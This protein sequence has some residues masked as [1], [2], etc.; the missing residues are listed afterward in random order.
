MENAVTRLGLDAYES[1]SDKAM[2]LISKLGIYDLE[3][4]EWIKDPECSVEDIRE[5]YPELADEIK[6]RPYIT[7]DDEGYGSFH[8]A[9]DHILYRF[10]DEDGTVEDFY[11]NITHM[12]KWTM[13]ASY[14]LDGL[15]EEI[16]CMKE[17]NVDHG[18][19]EGY[20][21]TD[22]VCKIPTWVKLSN[23]CS[24]QGKKFKSVFVPHSVNC[25]G[26]GT[27]DHC[28]YLEEITLPDTL[29]YVGDQMFHGCKNLKEISF[30]N[31]AVLDEGAMYKCTSL[32]KVKLP[33]RLK[34]IR[35]NLLAECVSLESIRIPYS[36]T[37]IQDCAFENCKSLTSMY[38]PDNVKYI[39]YNVFKGCDK[40][41]EISIPLECKFEEFPEGIKI[42][43]RG[44]DLKSKYKD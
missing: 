12:D 19:L 34:K 42:V 2:Q 39:G 1:Q 13:F 20:E 3:R 38:I 41:T 44:L 43:T 9:K 33:K 30:P 8:S 6:F 10:C 26:S 7:M 22:E 25:L 28:E 5:I 29:R 4:D 37:E 27:F 14:F 17:F 31:K 21:G 36:V 15:N 35:E 23:I 32:K 11:G 40:L 16:K 24:L 18:M